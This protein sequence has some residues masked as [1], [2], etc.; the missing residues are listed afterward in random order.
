MLSCLPGRLVGER[1]LV[2]AGRRRVW[3][4]RGAAHLE[5]LHEKLQLLMVRRFVLCIRKN[6]DLFS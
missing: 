4:I 1:K 5:E 2:W 3:D 6:S